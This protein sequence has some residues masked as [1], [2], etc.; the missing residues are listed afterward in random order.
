M[1][2]QKRNPALIWG[3]VLLLHAALIQLLLRH[4]YDSAPPDDGVPMR[5]MEAIMIQPVLRTPAVAAAPGAKPGASAPVPRQRLLPVAK[6]AKLANSSAATPA[7]T[8][9]EQAASPPSSASISASASGSL[10]ADN[11][12]QQVMTIDQ[13]RQLARDDERSRQKTP[14]E[15]LRAQQLAAKSR[16][17]V[18]TRAI[19][20]AKRDDCRTA[21]SGGPVFDPLRLIPLAI[22]TLTDTGCKW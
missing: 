19:A 2:T 6:P 12:P 8:A 5:Y 22:D 10:A 4:D 11:K 17:A 16:G 1:M 20:R 18:T 9:P 13:M 14:Q 3:G 7:A 15:R 21:Y